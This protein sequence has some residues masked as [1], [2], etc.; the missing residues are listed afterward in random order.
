MLA[1]EM[2]SNHYGEHLV[3]FGLQVVAAVAQ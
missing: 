3:V 1:D 2:V